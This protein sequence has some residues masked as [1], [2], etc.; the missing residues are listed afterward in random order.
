[1]KADGRPDYNKTSTDELIDGT[2]NLVP[3]EALIRD[4]SLPSLQLYVADGWPI[5]YHLGYLNLADRLDR[6]VWW[7]AFWEKATGGDTNKHPT[8][9]AEL[10]ARETVVHGLPLWPAKKALDSTLDMGAH[11]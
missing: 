11:I 10:A 1:L 4:L 6:S 3:T 7:K 5:T 8:S 2:G 9:M